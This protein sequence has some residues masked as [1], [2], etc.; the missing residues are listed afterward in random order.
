MDSEGNRLADE[1]QLSGRNSRRFDRRRSR[2][3][4]GVS[5]EI[6]ASAHDV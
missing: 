3:T 1:I 5:G 2:N 4:A 6:A